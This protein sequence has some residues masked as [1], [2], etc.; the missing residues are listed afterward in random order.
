MMTYLM[1]PLNMFNL[2]GFPHVVFWGCDIK[3]I[4]NIKPD[5]N[6]SEKN[7]KGIGSEYHQVSPSFKKK[8][9]FYDDEKVAKAFN[10]VDQLPDNIDVTYSKYDDLDDS[11]VV[12]KVVERI[13]KEEKDSTK[14]EKSESHDEDR[15]VFIRII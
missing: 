9:T 4:F 2:A 11:D 12:G 7:K 13:L 15:K 8:F 5:E 14:N 3:P 1:L 10:I 6:D